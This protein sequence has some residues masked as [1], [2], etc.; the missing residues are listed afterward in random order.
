MSARKITFAGALA[1]SVL[2]GL[3]AC[4]TDEDATILEPDGSVV[5]PPPDAGADDG[6]MADD[7]DAGPCLDCEWFP[8]TCTGDVLCPNGPFGT[9]DGL[10]PRVHVTVIRG[11][12]ESDVWV[13]GALGALAHFDGSTWRRS[14][15]GVKESIRGLWLRD[16]AEVSLV[17]LDRLFARGMDL[18][19]AGGAGTAWTLGPTPARSQDY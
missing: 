17:A 5:A 2:A 1:S 18:P 12:S 11:R 19:D 16:S 15:V 4:A 13:A 9:T 7:G 6:G 10:D 8:D 14:D 3:V